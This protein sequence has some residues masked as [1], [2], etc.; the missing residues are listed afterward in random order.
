MKTLLLVLALLNVLITQ[1]SPAFAPPH[2]S[3]WD[4][5]YPKYPRAA[6]QDRPSFAPAHTAKRSSFQTQINATGTREILLVPMA[7]TDAD[8]SSP[9]ATLLS[10]FIE[11]Y[12]RVSGDRFIPS[13]VVAP[14]VTSVRTM[15]YY[16]ADNFGIDT[17][18]DHQIYEMARE[19]AQL[20][21]N[22]S[23][24]PASYNLDKNGD[25]IVDHFMI[26]HAGN[27]QEATGASND[28]WSHMWEIGDDKPVSELLA[29]GLS[30]RN[31][32]TF[33]NTSPLG[34]MV[35][36]FGHDIGWVDLYPTDR[37][38]HF[39]AGNW[40]LMALGC[41]NGPSYN[42]EEPSW[43]SAHCR[44]YAGWINP[45]DITTQS[46]SFTLP[47]SE[48]TDAIYR[49]SLSSTE[50]FLLENRWINVLGNQFGGMLIW[51]VDE[52]V[53]SAGWAANSV[54]TNVNHKGVDLEEADNLSELDR[55][56]SKGNSGDP[57]PGS[58][59]NHTFSPESSP[60]SESYT[61]T[62][63]ST[64]YIENIQT[65]G[66]SIAFTKRGSFAF[67]AGVFSHPLDENLLF[68]TVTPSHTLDNNSLTA[69][70][71][72]GVTKSLNMYWITTSNVFQATC[73][74]AD[75]DTAFNLFL[76]GVVGGATKEA[77]ISYTENT[78]KSSF[79][80]APGR[81]NQ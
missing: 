63:R 66:S 16:G 68:I 30:V 43:P 49:V 25:G 69:S 36:E 78:V 75:P 60:S 3:L 19:A 61:T 27:A 62:L 54:N 37:S 10:Q 57:Y 47:R 73:E 24:N 70:L 42:G 67:W 23:F 34:I 2:P 74:I 26:L 38:P 77:T 46:G 7:F 64:V 40:C 4:Y 45:T 50:Y 51:H 15:S 13:F 58:T 76:R 28:I 33:A 29:A 17:S 1:A 53:L 6:G 41:W 5:Y 18:T 55:M 52:S 72:Q 81:D 44:Y 65:S 59:Q 11:Y 21:R 8:I 79:L 71:T 14:K 12:R 32:T 22:T 9:S 20:L 80:T 35:H 31:Y 39:G 56:A 48:T